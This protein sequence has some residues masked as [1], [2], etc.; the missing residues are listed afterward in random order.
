MQTIEGQTAKFNNPYQTL[1]GSERAYVDFNG[2]KTLWL[3]TGTRCNL[4]C[5]NC[6]IESTPTND[7]LSYL[8]LEDVEL[9]LQELRNEDNQALNIALTGGEPFLNPHILKILEAILKEG[10]QT[11]VLTNAFR[12]LE[13]KK[14]GLMKLI[15]TYGD[16]LQLRVSL[17]H[18]TKEAHEKERGQG[19]F[20]K[21]LLSVKWLYENGASLSL[22][23]R[24]LI[25][26]DINR[27]KESYQDLLREFD[28]PLKLTEKN[29]V[30]FPEMEMDRDVPEIT[31][32]CWDILKKSPDDQ[33]CAH[34]RMVIK[35]KEDDSPSVVAC[36]LIAYNKEFDLGK[37]LKESEKR[38]QLNHKFCAQFCVLGGA[39]CSSTL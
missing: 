9:Y 14:N 18:Y 39:S 23:G 36:T 8:T 25:N 7:R 34:E 32:R 3:N 29:L 20:D 33:M 2:L 22:A 10:Y 21:T 5:E 37:T 30:V 38:V 27:S 15:S 28:I 16:Q 31:T 26:E 12:V 6:Y 19:T 35:R 4:S 13:N 11:L 1:D 24:A 17:D